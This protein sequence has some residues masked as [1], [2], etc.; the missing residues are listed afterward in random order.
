MHKLLL[1]SDV[2]S[3]LGQA[4]EAMASW[5][6]DDSL[7]AIRRV[8]GITSKRKMVTQQQTQDSL[9]NALWLA[10]TYVTV[11]GHYGRFWQRLGDNSMDEAWTSLQSA[12]IKVQALDRLTGGVDPRLEWLYAQTRYLD[13]AFDYNLFMSP[14]YNVV[15]AECS[16][17]RQDVRSPGC[18][19]VKG[20]LYSGE[21]AHTVIKECSVASVSLV[22]NPANRMAVA[23]LE[24]AT[25]Q[26]P[27]LQQIQRVLNS[28]L[29]TVKVLVPTK[30]VLDMSDNPTRNSQCPCGSLKKIK[31][32]CLDK[33]YTVSSNYDVGF[34][35]S[36][37][38]SFFV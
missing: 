27:I 13:A 14:E 37:T 2:G 32:C 20:N 29:E 30:R 25:Y 23:K 4:L 26:Y 19:H 6:L 15:L 33:W 28:P 7:T 12:R 35:A 1:E 34:G 11:W 22:G 3:D 8:R 18:R 31:H 36:M 10:E 17:C 9:A 5:N 38:A 21:M 24:N 16:I